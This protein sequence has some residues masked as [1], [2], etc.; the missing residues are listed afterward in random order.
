MKKN[1]DGMEI[2]EIVIDEKDGDTGLLRNSFVD[3]PAVIYEKINFSKEEVNLNFQ[4]DDTQQKFISV[5]LVADTVIPRIDEE[6]KEYGVVFTK[7]SIV[8]IVN[9]FVMNKDVDVNEVSYQH[10]DEL[11]EGVFLVEHFI[12]KKGV[13]E[14]PGFK[15]LP[16][17]SWVTTYHVPDTEQYNKLK[18]DESFNGFSV[19]IT[20]LLMS[21]EIKPE[22]TEDEVLANIKDILEMGISDEEMETLIKQQLSNI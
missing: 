14:S 13:V 9:Q 1:K 17:G 16:D 18:A 19:E 21:D 10:T 6:G 4:V 7:D 5:S 3:S 20:A 22:I 11:I 8:D 12:T 2:Y 15:D